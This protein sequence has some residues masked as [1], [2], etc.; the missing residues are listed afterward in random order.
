[1]TARIRSTEKYL[2]NQL[3]V[4]AYVPNEPPKTRKARRAKKVSA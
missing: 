1:M 2:L 3:E 4:P